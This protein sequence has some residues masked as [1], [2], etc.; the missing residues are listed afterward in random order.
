MS[1]PMKYLDK[2]LTQLRDLG[3][4]QD[5]DEQAPI[6]ALLNRISDLDEGKVDRDTVSMQSIRDWLR[7]ICSHKNRFSRTI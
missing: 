3:L 2:A 1:T 6:I 7:P 5:K 4:V